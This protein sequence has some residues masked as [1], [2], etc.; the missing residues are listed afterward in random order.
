MS[1][2]KL[3]IGLTAILASFGITTTS[4]SAQFQ[5]SNGTSKGPQQLKAGV[6]A[7]VSL[8]EA[9]EAVVAVTCAEVTKAE[10]TITNAN[11]QLNLSGQF[12]KCNEK[13]GGITNPATI[14]SG[15]VFA[16]ALSKTTLTGG[17]ASTCVITQ[18]A[19]GCVITVASGAPNIG[20][21]TV[22]SV[23]VETK[24]T[25]LTANV[26]GFTAS[27]TKCGLKATTGAVKTIGIE[28]ELLVL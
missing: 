13:L 5:S 23:T 9:G 25:E 7:S 17:V 6:T 26:T 18:A 8:E 2:A 14:N 24:N 27:T 16:V 15:C 21:S 12:T 19:K 1:K 11:Q 10:W 20:L 4:A 22:T 28:H 3:L